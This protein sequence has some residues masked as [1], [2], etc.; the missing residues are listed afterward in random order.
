M[1][2]SKNQVS[3]IGIVGKD[4]QTNKTNAGVSYTRFS[5]ATS[6][7]GYRKADGTDV[8]ETT[9][10]HNIT[11]WRGLADMVA[12]YVTKGM[13]LAVDGKIVYGEY[14]KQGVKCL[15]V[16]IIASDVV[17]MSKSNNTPQATQQADTGAANAPTGNDRQGDLFGGYSDV[18][19]F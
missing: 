17:L 15:S 1:A 5:L 11:C 16:D 6:E 10:W 2:K 3:L 19:P 9:Q 18:L 8:P 7:G 4:P 12:K 14:E 13:K